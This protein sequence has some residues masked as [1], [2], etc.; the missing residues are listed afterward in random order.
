[1]NIRIWFFIK[2]SNDFDNT[3]SKLIGLKSFSLFDT[4]VPIILCN[5]EYNQICEILKKIPKGFPEKTGKSP[6]YLSV[7]NKLKFYLE[8]LI[9]LSLE[10][11]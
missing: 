5:T 2:I 6:L 1:M 4:E 8:S 7:C 10:I 11:D 3:G 9:N